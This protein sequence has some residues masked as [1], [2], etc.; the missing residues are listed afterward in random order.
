LRPLGADRERQ[1]FH[2]RG[3]TSLPRKIFL[4]RQVFLFF[5]LTIYI[6]SAR[7]RSRF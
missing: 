6:F 1:V 4:S 5:G 3:K 7:G 2:K